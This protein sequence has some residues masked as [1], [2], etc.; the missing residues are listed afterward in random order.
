MECRCEE[1]KLYR[2][3][4][5]KLWNANVIVKNLGTYSQIVQYQC[6]KTGDGTERSYDS[7]RKYIILQNLESK[8]SCMQGKD[9]DIDARIQAAATELSYKILQMQREDE[10][11]HIEESMRRRE[12][13]KRKKQRKS[14]GKEQP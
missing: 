4:S 5:G 11:F 9:S 6:N 8:K 13:E 1:L 10:Q 2:E 7:M 14:E 3:E 12:E